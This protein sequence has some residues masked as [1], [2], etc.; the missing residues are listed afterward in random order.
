MTVNHYWRALRPLILDTLS[1]QCQC[2]PAV[3]VYRP[4]DELELSK[5]TQQNYSEYRIAISVMLYT[6]IFVG[7]CEQFISNL[8]KLIN[9]VAIKHKMH[10]QKYICV[11]ITEEQ[12][13]KHNS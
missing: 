9:T 8:L 10:K 3:S 13:R 12:I 1:V 5:S 2:C 11:H 7:G 4:L 6:V